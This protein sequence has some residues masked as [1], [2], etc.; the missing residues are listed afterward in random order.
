[1]A[2]K[3]LPNISVS[4]YIDD[5]AVVG[6]LDQIATFFHRLNS[7]STDLGLSISTAKSSLL[8]PG[9]SAPPDGV[10]RWANEHS[11]PIVEGSVPLLGSTV[12]LDPAPRRQSASDRVVALES[13]FHILLHPLFSSQA[14]FTLLRVCALPRFLFTCRTLPPTLSS[15]ACVAFDRQ[16]LRTAARILRL[17]LDSMSEGTRLQ[18]S[19]PLRLGGFGLSSMITTA[20]AAFISSVAAAAPYLPAPQLLTSTPLFAELDR[21]LSLVRQFRGVKFPPAYPFLT[22]ASQRPPRGVQRSISSAISESQLL[23]ILSSG[24]PTLT[25]HFTSLKQAGASAWLATIPSRPEFILSDDDFRLAAWPRP[26][27]FW[28]G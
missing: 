6:P 25:A 28:A 9:T 18:L 20:P 14:S 19:L 17:E 4:A 10:Q 15:D 5:I 3:D 27:L 2:S 11:I 22:L 7:S 1:M 21:A 24:S 26:L 23:N 16:I 12:G 8:W 13:F